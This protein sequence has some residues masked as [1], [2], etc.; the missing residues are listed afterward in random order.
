MTEIQANEKAGIS[1]VV[2]S[3]ANNQSRV[4]L[5]KGSGWL[6]YL[7]WTGQA[8]WRWQP[9]RRSPDNGKEE[10]VMHRFGKGTQPTEGLASVKALGQDRSLCVGGRAR[11]PLGLGP[12]GGEGGVE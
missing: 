4:M 6:F 11:K 1:Q 12:G 8:F 5:E 10:M 7:G 2:K 9:V 3:E